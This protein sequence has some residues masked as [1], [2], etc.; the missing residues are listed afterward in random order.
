[1][2]L[3]LNKWKEKACVVMGTSFVEAKEAR[4]LVTRAVTWDPA[5]PFSSE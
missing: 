1:M 2:F 3:F 4:R 5:L